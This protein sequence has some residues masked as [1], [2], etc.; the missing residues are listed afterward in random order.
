M[1]KCETL[2]MFE[3]SKN[4]PVLTSNTAIDNYTF[5]TDN[6]IVY[7][8]DTIIDGDDAYKRD[9]TIPAGTLL[10]GFRVADWEG[11]KLVIDESHIAYGSGEDYDDITAGTTILVIDNNGKLAIDD[12]APD[13]GVYFLVTDK[14]T[15]SEN[16]V[17]ALVCI[18]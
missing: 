16:A 11:K 18:A 17:K 10:R 7:L 15:L 4:E 6:D 14:V 2:G 8:I 13:S 9:Y 5:I 3:I 12:S 1:I